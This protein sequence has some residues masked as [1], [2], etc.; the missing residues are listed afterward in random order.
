[1]KKEVVVHHRKES[2]EKKMHELEEKK[3]HTIEKEAQLMEEK[4]KAKEKKTK[5]A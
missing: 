5:D 2:E 4:N 1:V 3:L